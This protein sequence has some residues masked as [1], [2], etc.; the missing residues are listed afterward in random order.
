[1]IGAGELGQLA[2]RRDVDLF[3]EDLR[4]HHGRLVA[5]IEGKRVLVVGGGGSIGQ[6]TIEVLSGFRPASL[7]VVDH[8]EN[9]LAELVRNLRGRPEGLSVNDFRTLPI[10]FGSSIMR[11]FLEDQPPY[12]CVLCF[13]ALKHVRSEKDVYSIMQMLRVNVLFVWRLLRWLKQPEHFFCVSTDKAANPVNVMGATKRLMEHVI[14]ERSDQPHATARFANVAFSEGSLLQG[15]LRRLER[16]QPLPIPR[17][18][19]RFFVSLR[20]SGQ[21]CT[22]AAFLS[23]ARHVVVPRLDA[24]CD[25]KLLEDVGRDLVTHLGRTPREY[26]SE[27]EARAKAREDY[28]RGRVPLLLTPCDTT[29]E[30]PYE[31]FVG[32]GETIREIGLESLMGVPYLVNPSLDLPELMARM[33]SIVEGESE[34]DIEHLLELLSSSLPEFRHQRS[35]LHLD[36]RL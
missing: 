24:E 21:L 36:S 17:N 18:T 29:G 12:H 13:A 2:T 15:F 20:E 27:E 33:Q 23:P 16:Q 4:R 8:N 5:A 6:A 25:L 11:R 1:M 22:L 7:H 19:R 35:A 32:A 34:V 10:D 30:K 28:A 26:D 9:N 3:A 31:E 14:F